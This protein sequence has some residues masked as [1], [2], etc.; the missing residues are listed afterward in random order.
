MTQLF[1]KQQQLEWLLR[2]V[3]QRT[4]RQCWDVIV[5]YWHMIFLWKVCPT[6]SLNTCIIEH[7][8]HWT[9]VSLNTCI[10]EHLYHW[11]PVSLNVC[12]IEHMYH[13]TPVSLLV[14]TYLPNFLRPGHVFN[15][16]IHRGEARRSVSAKCVNS[17]ARCLLWW[18]NWT[19]DV[20]AF[21]T[22]GHRLRRMT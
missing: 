13:W 10:I 12:I 4:Y 3:Y 1:N 19:K 14:C 11:T 18:F 20:A 22:A 5:P 6:S 7:L 17:V 8:Y 15:E 9:S 2:E 21:W 16:N